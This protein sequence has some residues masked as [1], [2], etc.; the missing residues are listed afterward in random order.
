MTGIFGILESSAT[1]WYQ[2][3]N[4]KVLF[5][6]CHIYMVVASLHIGLVWNNDCTVPNSGFFLVQQTPKIG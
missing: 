5:F 3:V 4:L 1:E 6:C 2:D